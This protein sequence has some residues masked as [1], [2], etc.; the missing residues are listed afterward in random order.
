MTE[1]T[2]LIQTRN[3][4]FVQVLT[5][6]VNWINGTAAYRKFY[7]KAKPETADS[8][9]RTLVG[10]GRVENYRKEKKCVE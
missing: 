6:L 1:R 4:T 2:N 5:K 9:F 8:K 10:I 7:P 3:G